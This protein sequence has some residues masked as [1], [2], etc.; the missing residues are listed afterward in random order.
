M[1]LILLVEDSRVTAEIMRVRLTHAGHEVIQA[2][3]GREALEKLNG[4]RP[5]L[6]LLETM[7]PEIDGVE[8]LQRIKR[9]A[10]LS[11]IPVLVVSARSHE[12]DILAALSA[13]ADDYITKPISLRELQARVDLV[14]SQGPEPLRIAVRGDSGPVTVGEVVGADGRNASVRFHHDGAPRFAI[15]D[16]AKLSLSSPSLEKTIELTTRIV[17]RAEAEPHRTFGFRIQ[18]RGRVA[19]EMIRAFLDLIGR[20]GSFRVMLDPED[21]IPV[22]VLVQALG[23]SHELLGTLVDIS[24]GGACLQ[25]KADA[26]GLLHR[27]DS[28]EMRF[29]LPGDDTPLTLTVTIRHRVAGTAG[30]AYGVRFDSEGT[31]DFLEQHEQISAFLLQRMG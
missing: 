23:E 30:I 25:L 28:L 18:R 5:N 3:D 12:D 13:G 1:A 7:V 15:G 8:L 29:C 11:S 9:D 2:W 31:P 17:S 10:V 4:V 14:L 27:V 22:Q 26:D 6:I 21:P 20:R 19:R 16:P 24:M